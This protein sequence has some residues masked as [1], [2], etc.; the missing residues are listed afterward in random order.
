MWWLTQYLAMLATGTAAFASREPF[1]LAHHQIHVQTLCSSP[2]LQ[3]ITEKVSDPDL[4]RDAVTGMFPLVVPRDISR[5][6][7]D[8]L[9][10]A[11]HP[12][13]AVDPALHRLQVRME[14]TVH[15]WHRLGRLRKCS[16]SGMGEQIWS[17]RSH[18]IG[19]RAPVHLL[20]VGRLVRPA[21]HPACPDDSI[22]HQ[23][24]K[25]ALRARSAA[26]N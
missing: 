16:V 19:P 22:P 7:I 5:Q 12:G 14:R 3:I 4:I 20:P 24:L 8:H 25:D 11:A 21:Q 10:G 23:C 26:A 9:H 18:H 1:D 6:I 2:G 15:R 17:S 13:H